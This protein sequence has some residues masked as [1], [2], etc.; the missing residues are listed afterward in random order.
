MSLCKRVCWI[1]WDLVLGS[2]ATPLRTGVVGGMGWKWG[3]NEMGK[4]REAGVRGLGLLGAFPDVNYP[5]L[6]T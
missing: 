2:R 5:L 3:G 6:D 4:V 1:A